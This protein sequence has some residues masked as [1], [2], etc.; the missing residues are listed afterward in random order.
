VCKSDFDLA[1]E[2]GAIL[3]AMNVNTCGG[4]RKEAG[5]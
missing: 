2:T 4:V 3:L 5:M 1:K